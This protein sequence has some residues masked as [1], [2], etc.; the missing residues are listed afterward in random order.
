MRFPYLT[1]QYAVD[2]LAKIDRL[3]LNG[4]GYKTAERLGLLHVLPETGERKTMR[5]LRYDLPDE[6]DTLFLFHGLCHFAL[7]GMFPSASNAKSLY[8]MSELPAATRRR[9]MEF[10]QKAVRKVMYRRGNGRRYLCKWVA[11]WNGLLE[12]AK[13]VYP[14]AKYVTIVRS[15]SEQLPSWMKLQGLLSEQIAGHNFMKMPD[16][17]KAVIDINAEWYNTQIKFCKDAPSDSMCIVSFDDFV[18]DIPH[19]VSRLY[20]FLG[21]KIVPGSSFHQSLIAARRNQV[22]HKKTV[23]RSEEQFISAE[24][25]AKDFPC[26]SQEIKQ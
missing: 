23:I 21:Q 9:M 4:E 26:L 24:E 12:E 7:T 16:V 1:V 19:Q 20:I 22:Q 14:D 11:G 15:P 3:Y 25:I 10:H 17:R 18:K 6:D 8:Q 2:F 5:R 13:G